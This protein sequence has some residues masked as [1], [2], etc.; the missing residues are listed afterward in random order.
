M[1][2]VWQARDELLGRDVAVKE[3]VWPVNMDP[4]ERDLARRRAIREAQMAARLSHPNVV[5]IFDVVEED[6]RP[7]IVMELVPYRSLRDIIA[8]DG[9]LPPGRAARIGLGILAALQAAHKRGVLHRDVKPANVLIA[10]EGR[11]VLTDFGIARADDSPV[12]TGTGVLVGSPSY[13]S[14][15][16]ARGAHAEAAAD[17]WGLG[18]CLYAAVEGRPP[19][20]R[21]GAL[22][23]LTAVVTEEPD[24]APHAG[25]LWPVISGLLRKDP[26][27]RLS[28]ADVEQQLQQLADPESGDEPAPGPAADGEAPAAAGAAA[29]GAA[30]SRTGPLPAPVETQGGRAAQPEVVRPEAAQPEAAQPEAAQP[31]AAQPEEARPE[32]ALPAAAGAPAADRE[33]DGGPAQASPAQAR[34]PQVRSAQGGPAHPRR[35]MVLVA[36][37][38]AVVVAAVVVSVVLASANH[39]SGR[40]RAAAPPAS[41]RSA[42]A[43]KR[44]AT[45]P[46][47]SSSPTA[48][49]SPSATTSPSASA[50]ASAGSGAM[51]AGFHRFTNSTG[52][53]I[54]VPT[55]WQIQ[56]V[57]HYVYVRDPSDSGVFL[58]IDQSDRPQPNALAD[59]KAQAAARQSSYPDYH[60]L[61]LQDVSYPQAEQAADWEFTYDRN[62]VPV[63]ILNRNVLANADHAYALYWSTPES[64]WNSDFHYF[65][66]FAKTFRPAK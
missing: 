34:P 4:A 23:S 27:Q 46:S 33:P 43:S 25:P 63:H 22:A 11:V 3:I 53:S 54:G 50:S 14:P 36:A 62:G 8:D 61:R 66:A 13:I 16:R 29:A 56:H 60:L 26:E 12:L 40:H 41:S 42:S 5:G 10:P 44:P 6:D 1:G 31:E 24:P 17:L 64:D 15:E 39:S 48:R 19:F 21:D 9:P 20:D 35:R 37:A 45:A 32:V 58:L 7:W 65:Q 47:A 59:W 55:G 2:V 52:F 49:P 51:P 30:P 38:A 18:A 57:G 28:A